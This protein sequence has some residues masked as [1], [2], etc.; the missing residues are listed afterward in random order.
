MRAGWIQRHRPGALH[1]RGLKCSAGC[2]LDNPHWK[3]HSME[4]TRERGEH[5]GVWRALG[6]VESTRDYGEP[7]GV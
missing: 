6:S 7:S 5:E 1:V 3:E 4:S 2:K